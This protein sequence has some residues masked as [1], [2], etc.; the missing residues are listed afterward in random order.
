V[1]SLLLQYA[2]APVAAVHDDG[3]FELEGNATDNSAPGDD[4]QNGTPGAADTLFIPMSVEGEGPDTSYFKGGGSKDENAL[5]QW[6]WDD[7][8]V[9]PD[10]DE[11]MN[12]FAAVYEAEA[13]TLAYFGADKF[14][15]SGDA[16]I[17]FWFF[18]D[19]ISLNANG[20]F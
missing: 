18:Q 17:G 2:V 10:K 4:W 1:L 3:V 9:A 12:V 16:Q 20:N 8:D 13:G 11:L 5:S 14:D 19:N 7:T 15:D 6:G